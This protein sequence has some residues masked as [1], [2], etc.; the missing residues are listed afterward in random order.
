MLIYRCLAS[1]QDMVTALPTIRATIS[2]RN[3]HVNSIV[4]NQPRA[5]H[6]KMA[7]RYAVGIDSEIVPRV[8]ICRRV[9]LLTCQKMKQIPPNTDPISNSTIHWISQQQALNKEAP[10]SWFHGSSRSFRNVEDMQHRRMIPNPKAF[11]IVDKK[12][13]YTGTISNPVDRTLL[14]GMSKESR[15]SVSLWS[16]FSCWLNFWFV[17]IS[18]W[19][20]GS[21]RYSLFVSV[22]SLL[23]AIWH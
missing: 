14:P 15:D 17:L 23:L 7:K 5:F 11:G 19:W 10:F 22:N 3:S 6:M 13:K 21:M 12:N 1:H 18:I 9:H 8:I 20:D 2:T 4:F 16:N